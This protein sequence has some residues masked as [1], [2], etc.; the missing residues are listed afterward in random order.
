MTFLVANV[1]LEE[2]LGMFFLTLSSVD[3][4]F[5]GRKLRWRTYTTEEALPTTKHVKLV[6][7]KK[8][9]AAAINSESETFVV[10]VIS[11]SFDVSPSSSP[12][13]DHPFCS[14]QVSGLIVKEA[15]TKVPA[16]YLDFAD[17]FSPDLAFKLPEHT[18]INN[19]AIE[20]VHGQ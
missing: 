17:I 18:G 13:D 12:L 14:P 3:V 9:L 11:L 1:S 20:L 16:K 5:L 4:D 7:K 6:G 8:F 2:V 15:P 19:H 10:H